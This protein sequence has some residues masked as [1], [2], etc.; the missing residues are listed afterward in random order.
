MKTK[1]ACV[2]AALGC[3]ILLGSLCNYPADDYNMR[4]HYPNLG[5]SLFVLSVA[6]YC[7]ARSLHPRS[8]CIKRGIFQTM[9]KVLMVIIIT[10]ALLTIVWQPLVSLAIEF[11]LLLHDAL[12]YYDLP[13]GNLLKKSGCYLAHLIGIGMFVLVSTNSRS[14]LNMNEK[15][16]DPSI[17]EV[18]NWEDISSN[19]TYS[20]DSLDS[21]F[22]KM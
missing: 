10:N 7:T 11:V 15:R 22:K 18:Q 5:S 12:A 13:G 2:L 16:K 9:Y 4:F 21:Y 20:D 8:L 14:L 3:H 1:M 6:L 19:S 17:E